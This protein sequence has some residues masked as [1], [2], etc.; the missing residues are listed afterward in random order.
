MAHEME[1][2]LCS[3]QREGV[4]FALKHNGRAL[5]A[6]DMGTGKTVQVSSLLLAQLCYHY[7]CNPSRSSTSTSLMAVFSSLHTPTSWAEES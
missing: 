5:I 2:W 1:C 7:A 3:F 6:D 4:R